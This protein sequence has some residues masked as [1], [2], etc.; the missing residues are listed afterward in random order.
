MAEETYRRLLE[1]PNRNKQTIRACQNYQVVVGAAWLQGRL[2]LCRGQRLQRSHAKN[3]KRSSYTIG[4]HQNLHSAGMIIED[5]SW[6]FVARKCQSSHSG[7][8][9][10]T[11]TSN[12]HF[13]VR[14]IVLISSHHSLQPLLKTS[15]PKSRGGS[16]H[17]SYQTS[18][19]VIELKKALTSHAKLQEM[20][21]YI[22]L[23]L[24]Y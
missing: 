1:V 13:D 16:S 17:K 14:P 23:L 10:P 11:K 8:V 7:R 4:L 21:F 2:L 5:L 22:I 15:I 20:S 3:G 19:Q 24:E 9:N 12:V 6:N 18:I